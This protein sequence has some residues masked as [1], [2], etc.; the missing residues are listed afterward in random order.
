MD[1]WAGDYTSWHKAPVIRTLPGGRLQEG[2]R[3]LADYY[4]AAIVYDGQVTS[5]MSEPRLYEILTEHIRQ[6][7]DAV[8]PDGYMMMHDEIRVQGW[9]ASCATNGGTPATILGDNIRQCAA[10][11]K[12]ADPGKPLFVWS[13]M[14]DPTHNARPSGSYYLVK[15]DGPWHGAWNYLPA[16]ITVVSWQMDPQT[17]RK[18]LDHFARLGHP[19]ILAGYYDGDPK[20]ITA[21]LNDAKEIKGVTGV[22]YTTWRNNFSHTKEFVERAGVRGSSP[23]KLHP[24]P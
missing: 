14:F 17:R 13:D 21:W 10:I 8:H 23:S 24:S 5:C 6:V 11:I 3:V 20:M 19:Q 15:G 4:H 1:P 22:M 7:R 9:D 18:S 12:A 16:G 2:Q